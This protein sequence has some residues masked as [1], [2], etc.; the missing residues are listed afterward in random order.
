MKKNYIFLTAIMFL[1][2]FGT[3]FFK[4]AN[5]PEEL[6]PQQLLWEIVRPGRYVTTDQVAKMIIQ[7]NPSLEIIDVRNENEFNK[8]SLPNSIN[9]PI[10]SLLTKNNLLYFGIP[11]IKVVFISNDDIQADQAWVLIKRLGFNNTFVMTGGLNRWMETIIEPP[12]PDPTEPATAF[13]T[14][15]FRQGAKMYFTGGKTEISEPSKINV[16]VRKRKKTNVVAGGC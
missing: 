13:E 3:L 14:Y 10:D 5:K 7:N 16:Q 15:A 12:E 4:E 9:I 1:L 8:Y 11:D 2:A 6:E